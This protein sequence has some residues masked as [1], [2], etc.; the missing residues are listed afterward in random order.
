MSRPHYL[1]YIKLRTWLY[2]S[3]YYVKFEKK[4]QNLDLQSIYLTF[5][6]SVFLR[7]SAIIVNISTQ[8]RLTSMLSSEVCSTDLIF[9]FLFWWRNIK[10]SLP[11]GN[12]F[13]E[14][15]LASLTRTDIN[16]ILSVFENYEINLFLKYLFYW[17][18]DFF[19]N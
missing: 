13:F 14:E 2:L 17:Q 3:H 19:T 18:N 12:K 11:R 5:I 10:S 7:I 15:Q 9:V 1:R 16:Q 6:M 8:S 4:L